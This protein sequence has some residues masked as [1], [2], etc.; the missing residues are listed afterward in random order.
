MANKE[1]WHPHLAAHSFAF[2]LRTVLMDGSFSLSAPSCFLILSPCPKWQS[3]SCRAAMS[4]SRRTVVPIDRTILD[5][6]SK[7]EKVEGLSEKEICENLE[8]MHD[9]LQGCDPKQVTKYFTQK[10]PL[11]FDAILTMARIDLLPLD[12]PVNSVLEFVNEYGFLKLTLDPHD[13]VKVSNERLH[14]TSYDFASVTLPELPFGAA[15]E[16]TLAFYF[17]V[18]DFGAEESDQ[19]RFGFTF[20][21][22][23]VY[24]SP[25]QDDAGIDM[26]RKIYLDWGKDEEKEHGD[27][28]GNEPQCFQ[29]NFS[30]LEGER[31]RCVL[32]L[33]QDGISCIQVCKVGAFADSV[34]VMPLALTLTDFCYPTRSTIAQL[35]IFIEAPR[36]KKLF[37]IESVAL[38]QGTYGALDQEAG[39]A[40]QAVHQT[41]CPTCY[42]TI[43]KLMVNVNDYPYTMFLFPADC[44]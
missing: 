15:R 28:R 18:D 30:F 43:F 4:R 35:S 1:E 27:Y 6:L 29:M 2:L 36:C 31:V 10:H 21:S 24:F 34:F 9:I 33:S 14:V 25:E 19:K 5:A 12:V 32:N 40:V 3:Q 7:V 13:N 41:R 38:L 8:V 42:S 26:F 16:L 39:R 17:T 23:R 44:R 11:L 37:S 20:N 22:L